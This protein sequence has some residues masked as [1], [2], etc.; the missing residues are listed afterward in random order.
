MI[1][2]LSEITLNQR[3]IIAAQ[4]A[5]FEFTSFGPEALA[6]SERCSKKDYT[7][8][9][10]DWAIDKAEFNRLVAEHI[11]RRDMHESAENP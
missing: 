10:E 7:I 4:M 9:Q 6:F 3:A 8:L 11:K 2:W 1:D 5:I